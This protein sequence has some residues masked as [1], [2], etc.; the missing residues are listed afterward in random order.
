MLVLSFF[1]PIHSETDHSPQTVLPIFRKTLPPQLSQLR[2]LAM[3]MPIE[4]PNLDIS[5]R[6]YF[7][8]FLDCV[9]LTIKTKHHNSQRIK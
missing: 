7:Q 5:L 1:L 4:Q 2:K 9:K 6:Y 8:V 3:G